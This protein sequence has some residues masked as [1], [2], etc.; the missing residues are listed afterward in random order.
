MTVFCAEQWAIVW[1]QQG[2]W[3]SPYDQPLEIVEGEA[4]LWLAE[5]A[6]CG[7]SREDV[8]DVLVHEE[9]SRGRLQRVY[10]DACRACRQR[11]TP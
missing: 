8:Q 9:W 3:R 11:A 5:C 4:G 10:G 2:M 7:R 6:F 1:P